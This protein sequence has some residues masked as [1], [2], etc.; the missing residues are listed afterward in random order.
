WDATHGIHRKS[1]PLAKDV[2]SVLQDLPPETEAYPSNKEI[3]LTAAENSALA[4]LEHLRRLRKDGSNKTTG[5]QATLVEPANTEDQAKTKD[6]SSKNTGDQ[7][8]TRD[9][10]SKNTGDPVNMPVGQQSTASSP[11]SPGTIVAPGSE[12]FETQHPD[13]RGAGS[14]IVNAQGDESSNFVSLLNTSEVEA[15]ADYLT[16]QKAFDYQSMEELLGMM[17]PRTFVPGRASSVQGRKA[18]FAIVFGLYAHGSYYGC[19]RASRMYPAMCR[20]FNSC[21]RNLQSETVMHWT[22]VSVLVNMKG[23]MHLDAHN[24]A[25]SYNLAVGLGPYEGGEL[26]VELRD[27]DP[28]EPHLPLSW[29][30]LPGGKRAPGQVHPTRWRPTT[31]SPK[32]YHKT[33]PWTGTRYSV[34]AYTARSWPDAQRDS[35]VLHSLRQLQFPLPSTARPL[36]VGEEAVNFEEEANGD[37]DPDGVQEVE[38]LTLE[39]RS[40]IL[41]TYQD[42]EGALKEIFIEYPNEKTT[43][44]INLCTPWLDPLS[45]EQVLQEQEWKYQ[46]LS[47]Q[48]GC[49]LSTHSGFLS[50]REQ[51]NHLKPEWLWCHIPRGPTQLFAGEQGWDDPRR[52]LKAKGY[53]KVLRQVLLLSRDHLIKGGKLMWLIPADSLASSVREVQRFWSFHGRGS[54][55]QVAPEPQVLSNVVEVADLRPGNSPSKFW[56]SVTTISDVATAWMLDS[57]GDTVFPVDTSCLNTLTSSELERLMQHVHQ[58]HRRFG[59]PSNRLLV[60]NLL[61][62]NAD[63]KVV[64]AASQLEC[65]ECL[66]S[67]IK[68]PSP[69]VNLDKCEKLWSCLQ[70]DG[71]HLRCGATV[72]HFLLMVDEASGFA[73]VREMFSQPGF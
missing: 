16:A 29:R 8:K 38:Q 48:E 61:Y 57:G 3:S 13:S 40:E 34:I 47:H 72:Y 12:G 36:H 49:D 23:S 14:I 2:T 24:D 10:S 42:F 15:F 11:M 18:G 41:A 71:F 51:I 54:S 63:E 26:W 59:H 35:E 17:K 39:D 30:D 68:M 28:S 21:L 44:V 25:S 73:V 20:Y 50:A 66:E 6:Q 43:K 60:K 62:R 58:L 53:L 52:A 32:R 4:R 64:A 7:A 69:A 1:A 9:Q 5:P 70:V 45:M 56:T 55:L 46:G 31:F 65:D 67:Q 19:T 33:L 27:G 37:G 22:S